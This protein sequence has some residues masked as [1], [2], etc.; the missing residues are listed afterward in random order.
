M[1]KINDFKSN[2]ISLAAANNVKGGDVSEW[3]ISQRTSGGEP[4][5]DG[6]LSEAI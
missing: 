5:S 2:E 1:K 6:E 4:V 3:Y